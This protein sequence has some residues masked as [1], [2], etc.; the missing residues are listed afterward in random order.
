M[1]EYGLIGYPLGHSFSQK[2]FTEKYEREAIDARYELFPLENIDKELNELL[3][4]HPM[5]KGFNVTIPYKQKVMAY[6]DEIDEEVMA[7]GAVNVVK[8]T[9]KAGRRVLK[10][11]NSDIYGFYKS[12]RPLLKEHHKK[13]L[14]LGTGGASKAVVAMLKKLRLDYKYVSRSAKDG[15]LTYEDINSDIIKEYTVIV[16]CSPVG[17]APHVDEAPLLPY[18][19]IT[20]KHIAYDL[21]YNPLETRFL[22]LA[23]AHGATI[24]NGLEMLHL[25]AEKAWEIWQKEE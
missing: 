7:V 16:N 11:Y 2:Y 8:I 18:E 3:E 21:V 1:S 4:S 19:A 24:K 20:D 9:Y 15:Q 12:I 14:V 17:M 23:K 13:A 5:L 10:G 22:T 6:L 25:Q